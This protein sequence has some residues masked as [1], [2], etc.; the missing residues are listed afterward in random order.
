VVHLLVLLRPGKK[1]IEAPVQL[2]FGQS[3]HISRFQDINSLARAISE[4]KVE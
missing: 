3:D 4:D 2:G 1:P